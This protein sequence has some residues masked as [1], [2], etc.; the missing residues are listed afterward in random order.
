MK[1]RLPFAREGWI[2]VLPVILLAAIALLTQWDVAAILLGAL[3]AF[4]LGFFRDPRRDASAGEIDVL[5]PAD[6]TV[7]HLREIEDGSVWP[8]LTRQISIFLSVFDVHV[9]RAP[10][11]GRVVR[12]AY[13][14]GK[15][16]LAL[17]E[18]A[19]L[20]NEQNL[21]VI[22]DGRRAVGIRQIAGLLARRI[23]CDLKEGDAVAR[24]QRIGMI[25][26][27]SRVDLFL[28]QNAELR[29][30]LRDKVKVGLTVLARFGE[31]A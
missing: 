29:V 20:D 5:S 16:T 31:P 4:L 7:V 26:F 1:R 18:K 9:N 27:G 8:G 11:A 13:T 23:V 28:P 12:V 6:G 19:S 3:A 21:V 2:F 25:R 10:I 22:D 24:G 14:P 15:K 17:A 30:G